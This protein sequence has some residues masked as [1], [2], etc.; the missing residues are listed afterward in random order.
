MAGHVVSELTFLLMVALN[1]SKS[2]K[3][4]TLPR[5][6]IPIGRSASLPQS[7]LFGSGAYLSHNLE[8][9]V[10]IRSPQPPDPKVRF[11]RA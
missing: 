5:A 1:F 3:M 8:V 11:E 4:P 9:G 2:R 10:H 7:Q 6:A